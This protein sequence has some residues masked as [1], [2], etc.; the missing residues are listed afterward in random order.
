MNKF[1]LMEEKPLPKLP[2]VFSSE[3]NN[4][5]D[6]IA[7]YNQNNLTA[8]SEWHD[9]IDVLKSYISN[10]KIAWDNANR[11]THYP[12]GAVH[13]VELGYDVTYI[14]SIDEI[15]D[16]NYVYVFKMDLKP[17]DFGLEIP[18]ITEGLKEKPT[19]IRLTE[20][21]FKRMLTECIT[22]I[23]NEIA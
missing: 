20:A 12:N 9:Y 6:L 4:K 13:L 22:K 8:L 1:Y 11:Y 16:I 5:I 2:V 17:Q 21:Q 19:K 3:I 7:D 18:P 23:I 10:Q 14:V 15:R